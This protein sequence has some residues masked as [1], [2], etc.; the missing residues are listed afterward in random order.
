M[1]CD[2]SRLSLCSIA[3][4]IGS[5][6]TELWKRPAGHYSSKHWRWL[7]RA[8]KPKLNFLHFLF[9]VT[10][11]FCVFLAKEIC[12]THHNLIL[13]L[14]L[15]AGGVCSAW[16][17]L[18]CCCGSVYREGS[19]GGVSVKTTHSAAC[20]CIIIIISIAVM[21]TVFTCCD[22][23]LLWLCNVGASPW[24]SWMTAIRV[25]VYCKFVV[26]PGMCE[27]GF[28]MCRSAHFF[29]CLFWGVFCCCL[30]NDFST[31]AA[32]Q[33]VLNHFC[34]ASSSLAVTVWRFEDAW[35]TS[36]ALARPLRCTAAAQRKTRHCAGMLA[37]LQDKHTALNLRSAEV[38][39]QTTSSCLSF[40]LISEEF[41]LLCLWNILSSPS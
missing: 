19:R 21:H 4:Q 6:S 24:T 15:A 35:G 31:T 8:A 34:I 7:S 5:C 11:S 1:H 33:Y 2:K 22:R 12:T 37:W 29:Y 3:L 36:C 9:A 41:H 25:S 13:S 40:Y 10:R 14:S 16:Q 26:P 38:C 18:S 27:A 32:Q 30:E 20:L 39:R 17:P 28:H 23:L